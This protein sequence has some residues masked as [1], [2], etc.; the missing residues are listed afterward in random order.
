MGKKKYVAIHRIEKDP[1]FQMKQRYP[2][3]SEKTYLLQ[4]SFTEREKEKISKFPVAQR[5]DTAC[6]LSE[7]LC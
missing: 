1:E 5:L 6:V 3:F 4:P 2:P 7:T